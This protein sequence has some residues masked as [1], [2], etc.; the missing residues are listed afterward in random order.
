MSRRLQSKSATTVGPLAAH[1][2]I[3]PKYRTK[4]MVV[5]QGLANTGYASNFAWNMVCN[6]YAPF[7]SPTLVTGG[8]TGISLP[9]STTAANLRYCG[10]TAL[11]NLYQ[12]YKIWRVHYR[13][14]L[15]PSAAADMSTLYTYP[16]GAFT[17]LLPFDVSTAASEPNSK[18]RFCTPYSTN[19]NIITG[20]VDVP[21]SLGLTQRQYSDLPPLVYGQAPPGGSEVL[22]Q[23]TY[24]TASNNTLTA[25][26]FV[27]IELECEIEWSDPQAMTCV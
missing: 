21:Q 22:L 17:T 26:M 4:Q 9:A 5:F 12:N 18:A 13:V 2:V 23:C 25:T 20:V 6:S 8:F 15:T 7:N 19:R 24:K 16:V 1:R 11:S 3:S 10:S 27:L 14:T